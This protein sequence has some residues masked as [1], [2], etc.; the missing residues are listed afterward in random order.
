MGLSSGLLNLSNVSIATAAASLNGATQN[1][2]YVKLI[3]VKH[4]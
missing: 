3:S 1:A 2:D 4:A